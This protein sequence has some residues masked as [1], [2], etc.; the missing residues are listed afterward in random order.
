MQSADESNVL[1]LCSGMVGTDGFDV[2]DF[3]DKLAEITDWEPVKN[4]GVLKSKKRIRKVGF[5]KFRYTVKLE[6]KIILSAAIV[7]GITSI[8]N[9]I[10]LFLLDTTVI[11]YKYIA[12]MFVGI[13]ITVS[14]LSALLLIS[15][16]YVFDKNKKIFK[17]KNVKIALDKI[18][19]LQLI[20]K[21]FLAKKSVHTCYELNLVLE[22][23]SR[24]HLVDYDKLKEAKEDSKVISE[25]LKIKV[26]SKV[27]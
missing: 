20:K 23:A 6:T 5:N 3:N 9:G 8:I 13:V 24:I 14:C 17:R 27:N 1:D 18:H 2:R 22:D 15:N 4:K 19:A 12:L 25:F 11:H 7:L 26:W 10:F 16:K 21:Q